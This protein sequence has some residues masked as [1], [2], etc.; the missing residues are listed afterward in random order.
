[1]SDSDVSMCESEYEV[2]KVWAGLTEAAE[3]EEL[4]MRIAEHLARV[5]HQISHYEFQAWKE[6]LESTPVAGYLRKLLN[7][8]DK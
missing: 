4:Q 2:E 8:D 5:R 3:L 6:Y 7:R 1:M